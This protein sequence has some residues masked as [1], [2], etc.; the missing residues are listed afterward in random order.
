MEIKF[1]NKVAIV[2]GGSDGIGLLFAKCFV[3]AGGSVMITGRNAEK[4]QN[5]VDELNQIRPGCAAGVPCDVRFYDQVCTVCDKTVELFGS[6]DVLVNSAGGAERRIFNVEDKEFPDVPIEAYDWSI[7]VN[8]K[9]Q[10]HFDHA[11]MKQMREQKSGVII[12]LGSI[13]GE[14]GSSGSIAYSASKSGAMNGLTKS[15]ALYGGKYGVRCVCV[16][17]GPV[18]TRPGMATMKTL[19]GRGA[20]T[21]E[22]ID[23]MMYLASD[24]AAFITGEDILIDGG[25]NILRN[26]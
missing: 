22:V 25:R 6:I 24:K 17:P 3:E 21:Q 10:L 8:L 14:E 13:V 18:M 12:H 4:L 15:V 2:S 5:R 16:S 20:E 1:D 23:L 11:A 7:D 9:G 19:V 26:K